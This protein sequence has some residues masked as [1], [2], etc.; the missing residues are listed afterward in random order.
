LKKGKLP[1]KDDIFGDGLADGLDIGDDV[2]VA[3]LFQRKVI[4][5]AH[6]ARVDYRRVVRALVD[7]VLARC[8]SLARG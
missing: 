8:E 3:P 7:A 2:L 5:E 1:E 4:E 6:A